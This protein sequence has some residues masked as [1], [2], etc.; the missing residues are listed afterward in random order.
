[1][2]LD[3]CI[4][5]AG[6][7]INSLYLYDYSC[8]QF[9]CSRSKANCGKKWKTKKLC[10][11]IVVQHLQVFTKTVYICL[12][13]RVYSFCTAVPKRIEEKH[14]KTKK[15]CVWMDVHC[16][17]LAVI[18]KNSLYLCD[19]SCVQLLCTVFTLYEHYLLSSFI[20]IANC[21]FSCGSR[22]GE[23]YIYKGK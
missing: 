6:F 17:A 13:T 10:V 3:G 1:M 21:Q 2:C 12:T 4:A 16:A 14:L 22:E 8:V 15:L 23:Q 19:Y 20:S 9:L 11:W 18:Y 7:Y 5:L